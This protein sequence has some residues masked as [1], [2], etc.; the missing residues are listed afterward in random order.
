MT[1]LPDG[2]RLGAELY[3]TSPSTGVDSRIVMGG[4]KT[5]F[6]PNEDWAKMVELGK[7]MMN[8]AL[9][10]EDARVMTDDEIAEY[11]RESDNK[12]TVS[13]DGD[14]AH[15]SRSQ[16]FYANDDDDID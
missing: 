11:I 9:K 1:K 5:T 8:S 7:G 6:D 10:V 12:V 13:A 14:H 15:A 16:A 2:I 4:R 3:L